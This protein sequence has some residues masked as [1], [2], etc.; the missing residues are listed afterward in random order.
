MRPRDRKIEKI[1][2]E[3]G[4]QGTFDP[5]KQTMVADVF[6]AFG[7]PSAV[8]NTVLSDSKSRGGGSDI[9]EGNTSIVVRMPIIRDNLLAPVDFAMRNTLVDGKPLLADD[10]YLGM[11]NTILANLDK[12]TN[13]TKPVSPT[14]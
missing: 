3:V 9:K 7:I 13:S 2:T 14:N 4:A 11:D 5:D 8:A 6:L 10:E 12:S 1:E